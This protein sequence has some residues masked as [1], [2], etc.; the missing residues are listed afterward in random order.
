M[1][2]QATERTLCPMCKLNLVSRFCCATCSM[3]ERLCVNC[4][5]PILKRDHY[6]IRGR[7]Q[8]KVYECLC[9]AC[10]AASDNA[11]REGK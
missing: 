1:E 2:A 4:G 9:R 3:R 5:D 8:V 11:V 6:K 7:L 10:R